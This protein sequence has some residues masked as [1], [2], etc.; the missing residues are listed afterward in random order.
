[1]GTEPLPLGVQFKSNAISLRY[2]N[3]SLRNGG[4]RDAFLPRRLLGRQSNDDVSFLLAADDVLAGATHGRKTDS[5]AFDLIVVVLF[6][7]RKLFLFFFSSVK[8]LLFVS[9]AMDEGRA[10]RF[11]RPRALGGGEASPH[12]FVA[13]CGPRV[14]ISLDRIAQAFGCFGDVVAVRTA[15][16]SGARVIVSFAEVASARDAMVALNGARCHHLDDRVLH[17]SYSSQTPF[18]VKT[19]KPVPVSLVASDLGIPGIYLWPEFVSKEEEKEL[20]AAVDGRLWKNLAKRRVQHYGYEFLYETRNV[21]AKKYLGELPSFVCPVLDKISLIS[22]LKAVDKITVDQLTVNEYPAGVGLSPHIDT[23]SAFDDFIFS[24][25]LGGP[26]IMEFR[27]YSEG[28][29]ATS[30]EV[31][32]LK[33][34]DAAHG[35]CCIRKA[36]FLPPRSMLL[37]SGEGRYVWHHYIP[38]HKVDIVGSDIIQ[39]SRRVSF[40]FRKVHVGPCRCDFKQYCDSQRS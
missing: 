17:V 12:L 6:R 36:L 8:G 1:M 23:H 33:G 27:K 26:C 20:L 38:H 34:S 14:G 37:M 15:D 4:R 13:N 31:G 22:C 28:T 25:S 24:L 32:C 35:P 39:R 9:P 30:T 29:W 10:P 5:E 18:K 2:Q 21:D 16:D 11:G 40:T 3:A 19:E 7:I